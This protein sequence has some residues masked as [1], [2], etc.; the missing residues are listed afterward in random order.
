MAR[1]KTSK[2]AGKVSVAQA[3]SQYKQSLLAERDELQE[4]L[5]EVE[6]KLAALGDAAPAAPARK[7][8]GRKKTTKKRT[9]RK[10]TAKKRGRK[11]TTKKRGRKKTTKKRGRPAGGRSGSMPTAVVNALKGNELT[12][13]ELIGKVGH[14]TSS[15][16]KRAIVSQA[17]NTLMKRGD[18]KRVSRGVYTAA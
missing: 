1:K 17:I 18:I 15:S 7:K 10:K 16:N 14:L 8:R 2:R 11:K 5:N 3:E 9:T 6:D 4:Q 13:D 12:V